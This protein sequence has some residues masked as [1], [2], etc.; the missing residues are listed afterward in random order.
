MNIQF[1]QI[2]EQS[3]W[4][5]LWTILL[6]RFMNNQLKQ[7]YEQSVWA[8]TKTLFFVEFDPEVLRITD[9]WNVLVWN[10]VNN[11]RKISVFLY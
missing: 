6:N 3:I 7:I 11:C 5:D 8:T 9:K 4:T 1:K 2:Y 10:F